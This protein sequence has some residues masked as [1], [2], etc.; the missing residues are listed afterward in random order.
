[1]LMGCRYRVKLK[2][3]KS[4]AG[5]THDDDTGEIDESW[6]GELGSSCRVTPF[7]SHSVDFFSF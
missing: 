1:M 6:I 7:A 3:L 5:C 2:C 4:V